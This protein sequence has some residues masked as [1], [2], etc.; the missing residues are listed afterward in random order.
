MAIEVRE[1][2]SKEMEKNRRIVGKMSKFLGFDD[3]LCEKKIRGMRRMYDFSF[4]FLPKERH[5]TYKKEVY[6]GVECQ[7]TEP[8][9]YKDSHILMYIHGGGFLV[10]SARATKAY[11]SMMAAY[12]GRKVVAPEY[13]LAPENP[14]PNGV[15]DCFRVYQDILKQNPDSKI[16]L[17]GDSAG[18]NLSLVTALKAKE[19]NLPMPACILLYSPVVDFSGTVERK[20]NRVIR[21]AI[22]RSGCEVP[23]KRMY[24]GDFDAKDY[25]VSPIL[26]DFEGFP[27]VYITC[28]YEESLRSDAELLYERLLEAGVESTLVEMKNSYHAFGALAMSAKETRTIAR[29]CVHLIDRSV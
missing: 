12:S 19:K 8:A 11:T 26:G 4:A 22:V 3:S 23:M 16:I 14:Y 21:D 7:I 28:D 10:G 20:G 27:S 18:G 17:M 13:G 24:V 5:V 6:G 15:E 25:R 2:V 9:E 1:A 29:E